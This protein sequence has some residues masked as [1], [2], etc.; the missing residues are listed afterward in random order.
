[1][2]WGGWTQTTTGRETF[3]EDYLGPV[4]DRITA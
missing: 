2:S 1:M 3:R 4:P